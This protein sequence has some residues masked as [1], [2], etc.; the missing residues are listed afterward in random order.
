MNRSGAGITWDWFFDAKTRPLLVNAVE[1]RDLWRFALPNTRLIQNVIFSYE[2]TFENWDFLNT[3]AEGD[4]LKEGQAIDRKHFK[5]IAELCE[6][7]VM[8]I[9]LGDY[10]VPCV[11]LPYTLASD[12]CSMLCNEVDAGFAAAYYINAN[13][14]AVF[15]LRSVKGTSNEIDVSVIAEMFGGGGHANASG[16]N[17][18]K[19][20]LNTL[21][22]H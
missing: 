7:G 1:D 13:G 20:K 17:I 10:I 12:A 4:F 18:S 3:M 5:D 22:I 15:S 9:T 2:Y 8:K 6:V 14:R 21:L 11:N 16:F 19:E